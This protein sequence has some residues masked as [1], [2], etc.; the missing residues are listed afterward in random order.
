MSTS[1]ADA[2][3]EEWLR[4]AWENTAPALRMSLQIG[5]GYGLGL[6]LGPTTDC[7]RILGWRIAEST[8]CRVIVEADSP[9]MG[10]TNIVTADNDQLQ[11]RT[12]V[13]YHNAMGRLL[14]LPA[15]IVHQW[16]VPQLMSRAIRRRG[17][18]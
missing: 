2:T 7:G 8:P 9:L 13:S 12:V 15:K 3:A 10:A 18:A 16:L 14:W 1:G 17:T 5:W 6:R 11:W 4:E